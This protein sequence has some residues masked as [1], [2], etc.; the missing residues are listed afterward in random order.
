MR[1]NDLSDVEYLQIEMEMGG[2]VA[3]GIH[4]EVTDKEDAID[5][6]ATQGWDF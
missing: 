5:M 1:S 2:R 4:F 6:R 3:S